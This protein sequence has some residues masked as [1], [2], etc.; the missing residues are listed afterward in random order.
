[1][2][3]WNL[4]KRRFNGDVSIIGKTIKLNGLPYTVIG[5]LPQWFTFPNSV[6]QVWTPYGA[7]EGSD[8][9]ASHFIHRGHV[10]AR[11]KPGVTAEQ[12]T[13]EVS[14]VQHDLY[15]RFNN[16]GAVAT[17]VGSQPLVNDVVGDATPL[18]VLMGAV[19]CLL[20][21][22]C[23][24]LSNLLVARA[25]ARRREIA[26]RMA[27][28]SSRMRL[29]R[30]QLTES[31]LICVA[32]G[33]LGMALA[34]LATR[35]LVTQWQVPR[36]E[37]VH[38]D[39]VVTDFAIGITLLTGILS[40][41]LSAISATGRGVLSALLDSSRTIVGSASR[42]ALRKTLRPLRLR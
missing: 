30:E 4:F 9:M 7:E 34:L 8:G 22:A 6:I 33:A 14:A 39:L 13:Q 18:L 20:L 12:A 37:A 24:N 19:G 5:V 16:A 31:L 1:M 32:G 27:L 40:G 25:A 23:L 35:W 26:I 21:I 42:A 15:L 36:A 41:L 3:T 38:P 10:I 29:C 11:L 28:G 2:L 17:A